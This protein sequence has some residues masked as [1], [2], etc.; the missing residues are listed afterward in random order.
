MVRTALL[1]LGAGALVG[2]SWLRLE[3]PREGGRLLL[4]LMLALA[5]ALLPRRTLRLAA[6]VPALVLAAGAAFDVSPFDPGAALDR[7]RAGFRAF[8]DVALP[9]DPSVRPGMHGLVLLATFGFALAIA[10]AV[11]ERRAVAAA[12]AL[13]AGAGWPATLLPGEAALGKGALILVG[14]LVLLSA[15]RVRALARPGTVA[16]A[17]GVVVLAGLVAASFPAV[18]RDQMLDW[19][20]WDPYEQPEVSVGVQYAWDS[21]YTGIDFPENPTNLLEIAA[22]G[23]QRYWRATTLDVYRNRGWFEQLG[24]TA[25]Q[26]GRG[27]TELTSDPDLP[28]AARRPSKWLEQQ[29][30]ITGLRDTHLV[31][32]SVPVA[33]AVG[34]A[35]V[36]WSAGGIAEVAGGVR[37]GLSYTVWSYSPSPS[38]RRLAASPPIYEP[39]LANTPYLEVER[40]V[41]VPSFGTPKRHAKVL[42]LIRNDPRLVSY[43]PLYTIARRVG[44]ERTPYGAVVALETWLRTD[45][46]FVYEEQPQRAA[47]GVPP[48]VDFVVRTREGYCQHFAGAMAL[49]LR[50]LGIPARVAAGFTSGRFDARKRTWTVTDRDAHTWVEVWFRGYG[51][52]PFDPTP[53][54]GRLAGS[55]TSA[56]LGFRGRE[57]LEAL[58]QGRA[59][60]GVDGRRAI[61]QLRR[62]LLARERS[63]DPAVSVTVSDSRDGRGDGVLALLVISGIG[64]AAAIAVAKLIRRRFRYL[65]GGARRSAGACRLELADFVRDQRLDVR[66][67]A[68]LDE[69][70]RAVGAAL[71]VDPAGFVAAAAAARFG[72]EVSAEEAARSARRELGLLKRAIRAR[73]GA[74]RRARG[75]VSLRSLR[76]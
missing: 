9:F 52:L 44:G 66:P 47:P 20:K 51:W 15:V 59:G 54:R 28:G 76:A 35:S 43:K 26:E 31:G 60:L 34:D 69:L 32:A 21:N 53:G 3:E 71:G 33:Y 23:D 29:V 73:L 74:R 56:S 36:D 55:Y 14:A 64:I 50:Y 75:L 70:G 41:H 40:D 72:P 48:L 10:L 68:T 24:L 38:P 19:E 62:R 25:P 17:G 57:A 45:P 8:Y 13:V 11:R 67:A 6:C 18:A 4:V 12:A 16:A 22:A 63:L 61:E 7:A 39:E 65:G 37:R 42:W 58:G 2:L 5:P 49:M 46:Q 30:R 1:S 27:R